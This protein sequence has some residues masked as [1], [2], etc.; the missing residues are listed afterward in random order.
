MAL[1]DVPGL[2]FGSRTNKHAITWEEHQKIIAAEVNPERKAFYQLCWHLGGSQGDIANLD[3][4]DVGWTNN[5]V[6]FMRQKTC[7]PVIV[8]LGI[9]L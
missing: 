4:E 2:P 3:G 1:A 8:H 7:V 9:R 6:S 5:T